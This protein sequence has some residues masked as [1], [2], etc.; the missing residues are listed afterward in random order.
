MAEY[1]VV[2][3]RREAGQWRAFVREVRT[4]R[5]RGRTLRQ[6]RVALRRALAHL[7]ADP[8]AIDFVEDVRLPGGARR[9]IGVHWAARRKV[10]KAREAA[11]AATRRALQA[12]RDLSINLKD[13]ADLLGIPP[14]KLQKAS[15]G[16]PEGR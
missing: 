5:S 7:V 4:C 3:A 6:A 2:Y 11:D 13:A 10:E 12:L 16:A 8:Y 9:L 1:H 15:K 14:A